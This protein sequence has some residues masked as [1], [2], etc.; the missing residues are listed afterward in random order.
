MPNL[1]EYSN[2]EL[3]A[4][5]EE[6][7]SMVE[8]LEMSN[9]EIQS[10]NEELNTVNQELKS[11]V[12]ERT[13]ALEEINEV[14][15]KEVT[16]RK[17][18]EEARVKLLGQLVSAQED[19][20]RRFARDLHDQLGQ[21]LTTLKMKLESL[22]VQSEDRQH[23]LEALDDLQGIVRQLDLDVDFLAWQLRPVALDD[24]GLRAALANYVKQ[25]SEHF[26]IRAEFHASAVAQRFDPRIET[27]L[28][29]IAQEALNNCAKH[30]QCSR[31][32][33]LLERRD[34]HI[35]LIVEDD[36]VGFDPGNTTDRDGQWG[37]LGMRERVALIDGT[38]EI[39]SAAQSGT[40]IFVRVPL[41]G[42]GRK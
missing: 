13:Q 33:I 36:G 6:L 15:R 35:V 1:T 26:G 39:E 7:R 28:Y 11:R 5:N 3:Q 24:I 20:R 31:A 25:W 14:L 10:L 29:R 12:E 9:K 21:Q 19:E 2:E 23:M 38:I 8:E 22:R 34:H 16:Q 32:D 37:L 41:S 27:N 4:M 17:R 42:G 40:T 30:A 18:V